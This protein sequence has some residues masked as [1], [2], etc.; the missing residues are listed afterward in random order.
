MLLAHRSPNEGEDERAR[1]AAT[2]GADHAI[3]RGVSDDDRAVMER[4][5]A[6]EA[7]VKADA[8]AQ[9]AR[10]EAALAKLREQRAAAAGRA[11]GAARKRRPRS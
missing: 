10:K 9:R 5:A 6:L 1:R 4:L 3:V 8:D 7:E 2:F 11:R